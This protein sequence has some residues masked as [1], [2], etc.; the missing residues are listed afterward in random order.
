MLTGRLSGYHIHAENHQLGLLRD[1]C[2]IYVARR[3]YHGL[4]RLDG[5]LYDRPCFSRQQC[6]PRSCRLQGSVVHNASVV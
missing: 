6:D 5:R 3:G 2:P 1:N 4:C